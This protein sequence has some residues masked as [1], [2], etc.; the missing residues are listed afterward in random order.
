MIICFTRWKVPLKT[1]VLVKKILYPQN[2]PDFHLNIAIIGQKANIWI[3]AYKEGEYL[4][5]L[6]DILYFIIRYHTKNPIQVKISYKF[7]PFLTN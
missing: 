7:R 1:E 6:I 3:L 2:N 5:Y 4:S